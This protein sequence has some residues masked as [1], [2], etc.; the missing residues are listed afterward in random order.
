MKQ[1]PARTRSRHP[2]HRAAFSFGL[3]LAIVSIFSQCKVK[4]EPKVAG[5]IIPDVHYGTHE[6]QVMDVALPPGRSSSTPLVVLIHGGAWTMAGK[7]YVT[8]FRDSIFHNGIA[9]ASINHRYA[10]DSAVHFREMI[11][12]VDLAVRYCLTHAAEWNVAENNINI[13]GV[14]SGGHLALLYA[15]TTNTPVKTV[16]EFSAPV[17]FADTV[18]LNYAR[19]AGL[20]DVVQ[21]MTGHRYLDNQP[22]DAAFTEASPL[23]HVKSIP[24]LIVHGTADVVVPFGQA[25]L[26]DRK[27]TSLNVPHKMISI[28]TA[29]HDLNLKDST[30][31]ALVYSESSKWIRSYNP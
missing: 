15:F 31:R 8:Q 18:L 11:E 23:T 22:L 6:R 2:Y 1:Q 17:Q 20:I 21:K 4:D 5:R 10:N 24:T 9:I 25:Q 19:K 16:V 29:G 12:D 3:T 7:E 27:L 14:S 28:E 13:A 30:T 26:L